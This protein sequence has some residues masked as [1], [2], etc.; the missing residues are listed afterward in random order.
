MANNDGA[1]RR[2]LAFSSEYPVERWF[3]TEILDHDPASVRMDFMNSGRAPLLMAH[4]QRRII[5]I[6]ESARI[7][8]KA[9]VGRADVRFGR[10]DAASEALRDVEDGILVNVSTGYRVHEMVLEKQ[11]DT[12]D[13]YRI[14][15]WEPL[16]ASP[17]GIPA[18]PTVGFDRERMTDLAERMVRSPEPAHAAEETKAM[19]EKQPAT[20]AEPAEN[21]SALEAEKQ[22]R[23]AIESLCKANKI[24]RRIEA[25]WIEDGTQLTDG[26]GSDGKVI[27]GVASQILRVLEERGKTR[28]ATAAALGLSSTETQRYSLFRAI[29]ALKYG[30]QNPQ[31]MQEA[32]FE[33]ECSRAVAK[34]LGREITSN[35]LVPAEV[36]QK[37]L[38]EDAVQ[39]S[40]QHRA[41][42][43]QPG[44]AGGYLVNVQNMGF[45]DILRNRSVAMAM[46]ARVISGLQGQVMFPRQTGKASVTW[47]AGDNTS[48]SA[49]QQTL[50]QLS[51]TPKT[52]VAITDVSE[53]LLSQS[54]PSAEAFVMAD[55]ASA[56][57][58]D[59]V[60]AAVIGGAGGA[61]PLGI[62]N[63]TGITS[64]QDAATAT[65]AKIL[66]FPSTAGGSNAIRGNP[67]WV[68][69]IAGAAV[70]MQKARFA[71]T[72]TPLWTGNLLDGQ[73]VGFRAMSSEQLAANNLIFGSWDEV[74][75][76]EWGVLELAIDTGGTRFNAVQVG[77]RAI[78]IV[79]VLLRYPQSFVVSTNL[80]A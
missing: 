76:G 2:N 77:I 7:D 57:A 12:E 50:G 65:Y 58:I 43:T 31:F 72:D 25:R 48:V 21:L 20:A 59:G 13:I 67:G 29:R 14:T 16:E 49:T 69:N 54:S 19:P 56:V 17:V 23:A 61:Q 1:R 79:D 28:P 70:L 62:K 41:L 66:A 6:I 60:D 8:G 53:Q 44:S 52:C 78:W 75:I 37:P 4:D 18:D 34:K 9:K 63:T 24:D 27:E 64:G 32:A 15:D 36:L 71:N 33:L 40:M 3:G 10:G 26:T 80:S 5:G 55:L 22:R 47:Q 35:M 51:M 11:T 74:I 30:A 42:A 46:G 45:I 38:D 68:T 73:L 39:R